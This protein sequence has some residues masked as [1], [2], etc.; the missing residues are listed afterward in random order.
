MPEDEIIPEEMRWNE[1]E[2]MRSGSWDRMV[3]RLDE[4]KMRLDEMKGDS[5]LRWMKSGKIR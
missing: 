1:I 4:I 2:K 5:S 3:V